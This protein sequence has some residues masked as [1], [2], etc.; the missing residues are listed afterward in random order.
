VVLPDGTIALSSGA[1]V[2]FAVSVTKRG[3]HAVSDYMHRHTALR[4]HEA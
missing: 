2:A 4:L 3:I 1:D